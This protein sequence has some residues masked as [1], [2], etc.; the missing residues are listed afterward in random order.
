MNEAFKN[1]ERKEKAEKL[2]HDAVKLYCDED[3]T[4]PKES[5]KLFRKAADMSHPIASAM[6][7]YCYENGYGIKKNLLKAI[8][9]YYVAAGLGSPMA[10]LSLAEIHFDL[11]GN[12]YE[13]D[14]EDPYKDHRDFQ[15]AAYWYDRFL[16]QKKLSRSIEEI[17]WDENEITEIID[18][19][20]S[21]KLIFQNKKIIKKSKISKKPNLKIIKK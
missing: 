9:Y 17:L 13:D 5:F 2:Y 1:K 20:E 10:Q 18:D 16:S 8:D 19:L 15:L 7:G 12:P 3:I 14:N 21:P 11:A 6:T 4:N